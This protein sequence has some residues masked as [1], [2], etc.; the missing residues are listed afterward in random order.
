MTDSKD[1]NLPNL[2]KYFC[3]VVVSGLTLGIIVALLSSDKKTTLLAELTHLQLPGS[4]VENP[5]TAVLLNYR[6]FDTLLEIAVVFLVAVA[7][8]K[9]ESLCRSSSGFET[10]TIN[11]SENRLFMGM[12]D[13]L[14]PSILI[15]GGYIL[16]T[17]AYSPGGA[18]QAGALLAGVGI[19]LSTRKSYQTKLREKI[20]SLV[21]VLGLFV[22]ISVGVLVLPFTGNFLFYPSGLESELI[23]LIESAA[24]ISIAIILT[25]LYQTLSI[26]C[27]ISVPKKRENSNAK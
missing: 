4:G 2:I 25:T 15:L 11:T 14:A 1:S 24:T 26:S 5:V 20:L 21:I 8:V 6:S 3:L 16:W 10:H 19:L 27:Q 7:L 23:L 13:W 17:G 12:L 9:S 18:F 22:F